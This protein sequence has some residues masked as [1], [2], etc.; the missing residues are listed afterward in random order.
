MR[1][2]VQGLKFPHSRD[3]TRVRKRHAN[4][5]LLAVSSHNLTNNSSERLSTTTTRQS[6]L[7]SLTMALNPYRRYSPWGGFFDDHSLFPVPFT[8]DPF[9][10][11]MPVIESL[12]RDDDMQLTHSSP[13]YEINETADKYN[14]AVDVPGVRMQD[15]T[16]N[17][18]NEG[19]VLH[20]SGGRKYEKDGVTRETKF[21]KRFTIGD[22][23]D[24]DKLTANLNDGVLVLSAPKVK[25][26]EE[27]VR[28][29]MITE[30]KME[31]K[32]EA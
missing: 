29:I 3:G 20:I 21:E 9:F 14:I 1:D 22:N 27:P 7:K 10:E 8:R 13:G 15:M 5:F 25:K 11:N 28:N 6:N 18:E 17:L 12:F 31:E 4:G 2:C 32:K 30:G 26:T 16:V 24:K 23:V 19:R